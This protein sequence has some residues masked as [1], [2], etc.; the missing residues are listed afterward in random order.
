M[1]LKG[2]IWNKII[3]VNPRNL[4]PNFTEGIK[5]ITEE[6]RMVLFGSI[7]GTR[8]MLKNTLKD[9]SGDIVELRQDYERTHESMAFP[10]DSELTSLFSY[11]L[12]KLIE[13]GQVATAAFS[14]HSSI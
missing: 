9:I 7:A 14:D 5:R 3:T 6:P 8:W 10:P 1:L 12:L 13:R 4:F 11:Q 2:R